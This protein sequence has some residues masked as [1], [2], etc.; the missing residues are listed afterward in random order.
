LITLQH[1]DFKFLFANPAHFVA[2]GFGA[3]LVPRAPG[4]FG[5]L[6]AYPLW[7]LLFPLAPAL[8]WCLVGGG[9]LLGIWVC[10]RTG[11][12]LGVPDHGAIVWDEIIAMLA[13]LL[14][15]PQGLVWAVGAFVLFRI[16]D[17]WKPFPIDY[18]DRKIKGGLGVMLDD[19]LAAVYAVAA[20]RAL[21][22]IVDRG[23][24]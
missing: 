11:T 2:L 8:A 10:A 3:G 14:L 20:L 15:T 5:T 13:V 24:S 12:A 7:W 22:L 16:F 19:V 17:I 6:V 4:T 18:I 1:P 9:F 23:L 21:E